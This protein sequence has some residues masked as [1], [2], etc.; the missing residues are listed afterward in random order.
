VDFGVDTDID[1]VALLS[2]TLGAADTV[3][4]RVGALEG[5]VEANAVFD[6]RFT[7]PGTLTYPPGWAFNRAS[8]GWCFDASGTLA[9]I[10]ADTPRFDYN[11]A[12]LACRGLLLEEARTNAIRNPRAEG[13]VAGTPG[14]NP[15]HWSV[16]AGSGISTSIIGTGTESGIPYIDVRF[17]GTATATVNCSVRPEANSTIAATQG[18]T[19]TNSV[20]LRLMAGGFG[21]PAAGPRLTLNEYN[22]GGTYVGVTNG[23]TFSPT[24]GAL[25]TQRYAFTTT[26]TQATAAWVIPFFS[27]QYASGAI[28]DFT[29]RIGAWQLEHGNS[30]SSPM[31]PPPGTPGATTRAADRARITGLSIGAATL[32]VQCQAQAP[33]GGDVIPAGYGPN[34]SAANSSYFTINTSGTCAWSVN[35]G[36]TQYGPASITGSVNAQVTLV[37]GAA[38]NGTSFVRNSVQTLATSPFALPSGMDRVSVGGAPWGAPSV[39]GT[40]TGIGTYQRLALYDS[41]L[42]NSQTLA[43]GSTGSSLVAAAVAHDSGVIAAATDPAYQGNVVLLRATVATGRYLRVDVAAPDASLIDIGRIVAG[44]LWR[45]SRSV[46]YG[47]REGREVLDRRDRNPLTAAE[48]PVPALSNPR[49]AHFTLP[50]LTATEV[51]TQHRAL[52]A[53]LGGAKEA[54]WIPDTSLSIAETNAR[55]I[56]GAVAAPGGEA[57]AVRDSPAGTSRSFRIVE[58]T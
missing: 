38:A 58:R 20:F 43:L 57:L 32:L 7:S 28:V 21:T 34:D 26:I 12:T 29:I 17:F 1:A 51:R 39:V 22:S 30:A 16:A 40:A 15:T 53:A 46:A 23:A 11:P 42:L 36:G 45:V 19:W 9:Q 6:L 4:W 44:A 48:F 33:T 10:A 18:Q 24:A 14:T 13:A 5:L 50:L 41:R 2:T 31:L 3:R 55:S 37:G 54:L 52:L 47:V 35:S 27:V 56:W 49:V 25:A 8:A